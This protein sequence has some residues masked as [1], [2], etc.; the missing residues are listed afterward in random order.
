MGLEQAVEKLRTLDVFPKTVAENAEIFRDSITLDA[1]GKQMGARAYSCG[2][3]QFVFFHLEA[4]MEKDPE[5][6]SR[7]LAGA[8]RKFGD[9]GIKQKYIKEYFQIGANPG[10]LFTLRHEEEYKPEVMLGF[11]QRANQYALD[12]MRQWL[13][14]QEK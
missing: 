1:V 13:G 14:F 9:S 3:E 2:D 8:V 5:F 4:L 7:F 6:K 12:E 10:L 11:S